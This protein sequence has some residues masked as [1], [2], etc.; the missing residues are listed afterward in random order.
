V[1]TV[2]T[3]GESSPAH[4]APFKPG[5]FEPRPGALE[6]RPGPPP[7]QRRPPRRPPPR[8]TPRPI[9]ARPSYRAPRLSNGG[10]RGAHLWTP[11]PGSRAWASSPLA[12]RLI[13]GGLRDVL[14]LRDVAADWIWQVTKAPRPG[15]PRRPPRRASRRLLTRQVSVSDRDKL[16]GLPLSARPSDGDLAP[17]L[18]VPLIPGRKAKAQP[19]IA[20]KARGSLEPRP[21]A[22]EP[23]Q[24]P[25]RRGAPRRPPRPGR[26]AGF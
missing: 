20:R 15:A 18:A 7:G 3:E 10:P 21:G 16:I 24:S 11:R 19:R 25:S 5:A 6:P 8:G 26:P 1:L 2:R 13:T 14:P 22:L 17:A 12:R 9:P 4:P 23:R